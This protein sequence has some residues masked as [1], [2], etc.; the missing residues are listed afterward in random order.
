M[1][2]SFREKQLQRFWK[3]DLKHGIPTGIESALRRKLIMIAAATVLTDLRSPPSNHLDRLRGNRKG[4]HS[5]RVNR[6]WRL[7]FQWQDGEAYEIELVD[8]H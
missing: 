2:G 7:V 1:I 6:Q 3:E 5:I 4:Q 8:Y